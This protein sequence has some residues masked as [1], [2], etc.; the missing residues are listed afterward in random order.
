M[1]PQR[2]AVVTLFRGPSGS[3]YT[4][5]LDANRL[6][7]YWDSPAAGRFNR[8]QRLRRRR[9]GGCGAT[10]GACMLRSRP[11]LLRPCLRQVSRGRSDRKA[12]RYRHPGPRRLLPTFP[13]PRRRPAIGH[14][15]R[16]NRDGPLTTRS[17]D[18]AFALGLEIAQPQRPKPV[19]RPRRF[20]LRRCNA[21][22][23]A[24][25]GLGPR[26]PRP[27]VRCDR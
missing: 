13:G 11:R 24:L 27:P 2:M 17:H 8:S 23:L 9:P 19:N 10:V 4:T 21:I 25:P 20:C 12:P 14:E 22:V 16:L 3:S 15:G 7:L 26:S 5:S 1:L 18:V 6:G